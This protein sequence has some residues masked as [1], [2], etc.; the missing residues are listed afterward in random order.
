MAMFILK[1]VQLCSPVNKHNEMIML[2]GLIVCGV[3]RVFVEFLRI[4]SEDFYKNNLPSKVFSQML[5]ALDKK[6]PYSCRAVLFA[7]MHAIQHKNNSTFPLPLHYT[8]NQL[9]AIKR[10]WRRGD[11]VLDIPL[12][13]T[14]CGVCSHIYTL[15]TRPKN[16][17]KKNYELGYRKLAKDCSWS[18]CFCTRD[19]A[20]LNPRRLCA[21]TPVKEE[22]LLGNVIRINGM[23]TMLC[24]GACCGRCM[25]LDTEECFYTARGYVCFDCTKAI[26]DSWYD[27]VMRTCVGAG[28][29]VCAWDQKVLR[30]SDTD[31]DLPMDAFLFPFGVMIC[32]TCMQSRCTGLSEYLQRFPDPPRDEQD[33]VQRIQHYREIVLE[34]IRQKN[35]T[36]KRGAAGPVFQGV[37]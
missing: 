28:E 4:A 2:T 19:L 1:W 21:C 15:M 22:L 30:P 9:D 5:K 27:R 7:C 32:G 12:R 23:I 34:Q 3:P 36:I 6:F 18:L 31:S 35:K 14:Y 13:I 26:R 33:M 24:P 25:E 16:P 10:R 11:V 37:V 29:W 17:Y 20:K 8:L